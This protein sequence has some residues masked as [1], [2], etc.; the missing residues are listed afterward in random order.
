MISA[1]A[2]AGILL[3]GGLL[4]FALIAVALVLSNPGFFER[5]REAAAPPK[6]WDQ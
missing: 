6:P 2:L 3:C 4:V 1:V 5:K